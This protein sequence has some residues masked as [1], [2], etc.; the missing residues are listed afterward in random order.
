MFRSQRNRCG[1]VIG[2]ARAQV[3]DTHDAQ[4]TNGDDADTDTA[5]ADADD[6]AGPCGNIINK[7]FLKLLL[8]TQTCL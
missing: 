5:D 2:V 4:D 6:D 8:T 1:G 3:P 7:C